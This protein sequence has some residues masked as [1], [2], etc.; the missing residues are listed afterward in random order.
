MANTKSY[1][2]QIKFEGEMHDLLLKA[3]QIEVELDGSPTT[4]AA[5]L[6]AMAGDIKAL[7]TLQKVTEAITEAVSKTGHARFEKASKVPDVGEAE[8]NILYLVMNAETKHYDIYA[9]IKDDDGD[10]YTM[11]LL[12]DTT[13]DLTNYIQKVTGAVENNIAVFDETGS[14]K[15]SGKKTGNSALA[16]EPDSNTLA[17][18]AAVSA[19]LADKADKSATEAALAGKASKEDVDAIPR[20][21]FG[22]EMPGDMKNGDLFIHV[23]NSEA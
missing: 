4:L 17:T 5:V 18:E 11:Q 23:V 20:I 8:D 12:D 9:K 6:V 14:I 15:D 19:A 3:K 13:V 16:P 1:L 21:R 22:T 7:P 10:N 2:E